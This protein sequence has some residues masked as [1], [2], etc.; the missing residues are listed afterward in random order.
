MGVLRFLKAYNPESYMN[1]SPTVIVF[2]TQHLFTGGIESHLQE[3]CRN[4]SKEGIKIDLVITNSTMDSETEIFFRRVC[5][6]VYLGKYGRSPFRLLWLM[7]I[8]IRLRLKKYN[9]L[10]SNGQGE[11][12]LFFQKFIK[13]NR[14][15]HHHHTAGNTEDQATWGKQYLQVLQQADTIIACS[16]SNAAD[17]RQSLNRRINII[18]CF[19]RNA[20]TDLMPLHGSEKMNLGYYGRLIPEKGIDVICQ[21]SEDPDL[22]DVEFHVWGEGD[23]YPASFFTEFPNVK[24]HGTFNGKDELKKIL[25]F[26][27][28]LL[29][30]ST[31]SEG[32]PICLLEAMSAGLPWLATDKG[33]LRDI[34]CDPYTTRVIPASSSYEEI[35]KAV[36]SMV[37]DLKKGK[38]PSTSQ[39]ELYSSNFSASSIISKWQNAFGLNQVDDEYK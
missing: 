13:T 14:W 7:I 16:K 30:L 33:G 19:S 1:Y 2:S 8:G 31:H 32:L 39:M 24:Y 10:Y 29:L 9:A 35:K 34:A 18:P 26:L 11:S 3:F 38:I 5:N 15:V 4:L 36:S 21:L 20:Y 6:S 37:S 23:R 27:N 28:A 17:M 22:R 25:A 12:I